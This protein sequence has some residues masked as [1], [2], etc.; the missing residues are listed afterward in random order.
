MNT[1]MAV[2]KTLSTYG[3]SRKLIILRRT[4]NTGESAEA[5]KVE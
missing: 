4:G 3:E 5:T 1:V 2:G